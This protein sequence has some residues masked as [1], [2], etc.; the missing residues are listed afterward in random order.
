MKANRQIQFDMGAALSGL[1][2]SKGLSGKDSIL[3]LLIKQ[4]IEAT[5]QSELD[6]HLAHEWQPNWRWKLCTGSCKLI[7]TKRASPRKT[8]YSS[9]CMPAY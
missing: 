4:L 7:K 6:E 3:T 2:E 1:R 8:V 5:I 9:S